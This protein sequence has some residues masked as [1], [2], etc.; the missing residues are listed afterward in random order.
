MSDGLLGTVGN[1]FS[2]FARDFP[3]SHVH[4]RDTAMYGRQVFS[5]Q[6]AGGIY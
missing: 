5:Y 1:G 2:S 4:N 3:G 6:E